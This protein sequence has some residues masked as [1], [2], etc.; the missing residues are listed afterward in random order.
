MGWY[1][2][3]ATSAQAKR[4]DAT[5]RARG[6]HKFRFSVQ[7]ALSPRPRGAAQGSQTAWATPRRRRSQSGPRILPTPPL[8]APARAGAAARVHSG[9]SGRGGGADQEVVL[10]RP[11][12]NGCCGVET[13]LLG[14]ASLCTAMVVHSKTHKTCLQKQTGA[15]RGAARTPGTH[16]T[17]FALQ[18]GRTHAIISA[19]RAALGAAG[20]SS[21]P[22]GRQR[23]RAPHGWELGRPQPRHS[24]AGSPGRAGILRREPGGAVGGTKP[25]RKTSVGIDGDL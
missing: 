25:P 18:H 2:K 13:S 17:L 9:G 16:L 5:Q 23:R 19:P 20:A 8:P 3:R 12:G 7:G 6:L 24:T 14:E 11:P 4:I 15:A 1:N 21:G 22:F 10:Q